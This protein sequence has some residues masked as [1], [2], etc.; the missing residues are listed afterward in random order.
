VPLVS[1]PVRLPDLGT[2]KMNKDVERFIRDEMRTTPEAVLESAAHSPTTLPVPNSPAPNEMWLPGLRM[3]QWDAGMSAVFGP[4][5]GPDLLIVGPYPDRHDASKSMLLQGNVGELLREEI[6]KLAP[7]DRVYYT[8]VGRFPVPFT[9]RKFKDGWATAGHPFCMTELLTMK[10]HVKL[11]VV[12]GTYG[13]KML[14]GKSA[15]VTTMRGAVQ[16]WRGTPVVVATNPAQFL[17]G[18]AAI[19]PWREEMHQAAVMVW[20]DKT[21]SMYTRGREQDLDHRLAIGVDEW[22]ALTDYIVSQPHSTPDLRVI[23]FEWGNDCGRQEFGYLLSLQVS[24]GPKKAAFFSFRRPGAPE[25]GDGDGYNVIHEPEDMPRI[26][27]CIR[28]L[29]DQDGMRLGGHSIRSDIK[30]L[31][32]YEGI[33]LTHKLKDAFDTMLVYH[34]LHQDDDMGLENLVWR[35][36]P[37]I[38][39]YWADLEKWLDDHSRS[40]R[41]RFGYRD[42]PAGILV[43][44]GQ[45]DVDA[46]YR[47][48][49]ALM[50]EWSGSDY[51]RIRALYWDRVMPANRPLLEME[52]NGLR[53]DQERMEYLHGIF[54][55]KFEQLTEEVREAVGFDRWSVRKDDHVREVLFRNLKYKAKKP[56]AVPGPGTY[57][58]RVYAGGPRKGQVKEYLRKDLVDPEELA[59]P[60]KFNLQDVFDYEG[61]RCLDLEPI[62]NTDKYPVMWEFIREDRMERFH[63]PSTKAQSLK[64]MAKLEEA[65]DDPDAKFAAWLLM[66]IHD[67]KVVD[68]FLKNFLKRP[69]PNEF[70]V[71]H[72]VTGEVIQVHED[73]KSFLECCRQTD[74][75]VSGTLLQT[76]DTGRGRMFA[77][78]LMV[79][80]KKQEAEI[81]RI[82]KDE[83]ER[84][85]VELFKVKSCVVPEGF[86][87]NLLSDD[88][89]M[90]VTEADFQQA[91][92]WIMAIAGR[93]EAMLKVLKAGRDLHSENC[94]LSF[95]PKLPT[96]WMW[97]G[98]DPEN[99]TGFDAEEE[100][101]PPKPGD[102]FQFVRPVVDFRMLLDEN[103]YPLP[104]IGQQRVE[105]DWPVI[106]IEGRSYKHPNDYK[107]WASVIKSL[108]GHL[109]TAAKTISFGVPYGRGARALQ[110]EIAKEGIQLT[111]EETQ[112]IIDTFYATYPGVADLLQGARDS[113][114]DPAREYVENVFGRRRYFTGVSKLDAGRQAAAQR[115]AGNFPI[116]GCVAD[117]LYTALNNLYDMRHYTEIGRALQYRMLLIIHDAILFEHRRRDTEEIHNLIRFCMS[118]INPVGDTGYSLGCDIETFDR[119]GEHAFYV[120]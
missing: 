56:H 85:D 48:A 15:K 28:R 74:G 70:R 61:A 106:D 11:I 111:V 38:G 63:T 113:A 42:I 110:R 18:H 114:V 7:L 69:T 82:F 100:G 65:K 75:R 31:L 40:Q 59:N 88:D 45:W 57:V 108:L 22:E 55:A 78:N 107:V 8:T 33:D 119:W 99:G 34:L 95:H 112:Q 51:D 26:H 30:A 98:S 68:Q 1:L 94:A 17:M 102:R 9:E 71:Q 35:Y 3:D 19:D 66:K 115:E 47:I 72:P 21:Q 39:P 73:G 49:E 96:H 62:C 46:E 16:D 43:P 80:P 117:L 12:L 32:D 53:L 60:K 120:S 83:I 104:T 50:Q 84:G 103:G 101:E 36:I 13:A 2:C 93:D 4:V 20:G 79:F 109:R 58:A 37:E 6:G 24:W 97:N 92:S 91:E 44:Y 64:S 25:S 76:T 29:M 54:K 23:D 27:N 52:R 86:N 89:D 5:E 81:K 67:L 118:E 87:I 105:H 14:F 90:V 116:Q 10:D 77:A 41:L